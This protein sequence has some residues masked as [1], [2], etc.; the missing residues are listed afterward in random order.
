MVKACQLYHYTPEHFELLTEDEAYFASHFK[1]FIQPNTVTWLNYH[2]ISDTNSIYALMDSLGLDKFLLDEI[3]SGFSRAKL[4][5]FEDY[6]YFKIKSVSPINSQSRLI[7]EKLSF[8]LG[9]NFLISFQERSSDHFP[10]VRKRIEH[11][12][13]KVRQKEAD[14]LLYKL[15]DAIVENYF[16][17][18]ESIVEEIERLD[19]L[20]MMKSITTSTIKDTLKL[21]EIQ[22]RR[23]I[24]L[25]KIV[26]P[27]KEVGIQI[28]RLQVPM[29]K[30]ENRMYFSKIHESCTWILEEIE[31]NKQI[32]EGLTNLCYSINESKMNEIM[33]L[34]TLVSTIFIPLTFIVGVYGMNFRYM[35]ELNYRYGYWVVW[36]V[37]IV[38]ALGMLYYFQRKGWFKKNSR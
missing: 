16:E 6:L 36:G 30:K 31:A 28:Q 4:E 18:M 3:Q 19:Q 35:P 26:S 23:L 22:K 14:F 11:K 38:V 33:K 34:L 1:N 2:Q 21:I 5:E 13:G 32:L 9:A 12:I 25:R 37:M 29:I 15:L 27:L 10:D 8:I 20:I 7:E 24:Q 17:A